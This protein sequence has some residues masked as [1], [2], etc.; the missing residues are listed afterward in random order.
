[1]VVVFELVLFF[2]VDEVL[3]EDVLFV[4]VDDLFVVDDDLFVEVDDLLVEE[5]LE[6]VDDDVLLLV[7]LL[8]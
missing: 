7:V 1:M 6:E 2:V 4:V 5:D 8:F 3:L